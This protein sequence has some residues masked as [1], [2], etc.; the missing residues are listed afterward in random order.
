MALTD[1]DRLQIVS[2]ALMR[3]STITTGSAVDIPQ[4][5]VLFVGTIDSYYPID[6]CE[7][8]CDGV[9]D[10]VEINAAIAALPYGGVVLLGEGNF[11]LS[12]PIVLDDEN[13]SI[14]GMGRQ[15]TFL[16]RDWISTIYEGL[17]NCNGAS[18]SVIS[19]IYFANSPDVE[20]ESTYNECIDIYGAIDIIVADCEFYSSHARNSHIFI[21]YA[22]QIRLKNNKF[23]GDGYAP[24]IG[25]YSIG[26][27]VYITEN[28]FQNYA[29]ASGI[30]NSTDYTQ[31][32]F[33]QNNLFNTGTSGKDLVIIDAIYDLTITNNH[34][35]NPIEIAAAATDSE[36]I[37][38]SGNF[39]SFSR[40]EPKIILTNL[41]GATI[42][43]NKSVGKTGIN[44][45]ASG[46]TRCSIANNTIA[47]SW[48]SPGVTT[49]LSIANSTELAIA[50]NVMYKTGGFQ[51]A[52]NSIYLDTV[53]NSTVTGNVSYGKAVVEVNCTGNTLANN[54]A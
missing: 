46:L 47:E 52:D 5:P 53:T 44:I 8:L 25:L 9:D 37:N 19:G 35:S 28:N 38:I 43:N 15:A 40:A 26:G 50:G 27:A 22:D 31:Y 54:I 12:A 3:Y 7:Y 14:I 49:D 21:S 51:A 34:F 17:I 39:I 29:Q 4:V 41:Q 24:A 2:M 45:Q 13:I 11:Y 6:H 20:L 23:S 42:S 16:I 48:S 30:I 32:L 1:A 10:Q 33:I 18:T 36:G